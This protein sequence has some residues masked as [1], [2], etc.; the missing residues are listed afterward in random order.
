MSNQ[1]PDQNNA[2]SVPASFQSRVQPWLHTCFGPT[3]AGDKVERV[4][5]YVEESIELAQS[6][7]GT[8]ERSHALVDYVFDRAI[9]ESTQEVGGVMVTLA[10]L[11]GAFGMDM[12]E[13]GETELARINQPDM[14]IRIR[15]K[16]KAKPSM[17]PLPG[18]YPERQPYVSPKAAQHMTFTFKHEGSGDIKTVT[19]THGQIQDMLNNELHDQLAN[20]LCQC[21]P[22]GETNVV[23][24]GCEDYIEGFAL[25]PPQ[26]IPVT[27]YAGQQPALPSSDPRRQQP[28]LLLP[29]NLL[30]HRRAW[31][32]AM[33]RLVEL[34]PVSTQPD[35]DDKGYWEH[36]LKAMRAMYADLDTLAP[37]ATE[38][39]LAVPPE[40]PHM[41]VFDDADRQPLIFA[42]HGARDAALRTWR[43]ISTSWNAHLFVKVQGNNRSDQSPTASV[44]T[45]S[46]TGQ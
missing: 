7:G 8:R 24:C 39:A 5:R 3:I 34:E 6:A 13:C 20:D 42:G 15:E 21:E 46:A 30:S 32:E 40:C 18:V 2:V 36:E 29:D 44:T 22:I 28:S 43:D 27:N 16:Q 11:C 33:E 38:H 41:I 19:L 12:H 31:L 37:V 10:A 4:D 9:G 17:S 23:E 1:T 25:V 14:I 45:H 35:A 26:S